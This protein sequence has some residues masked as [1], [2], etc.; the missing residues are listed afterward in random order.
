VLRLEVLFP[1]SYILLGEKPSKMRWA[2]HVARF[3]GIKILIEKPTDTVDTP[4]IQQPRP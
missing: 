3:R 1:Q 4:G 2:E